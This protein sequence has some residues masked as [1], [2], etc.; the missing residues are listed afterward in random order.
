MKRLPI[1]LQYDCNTM[2]LCTNVTLFHFKYNFM[3]SCV[4]NV[5][6]SAYNTGK[7]AYNFCTLLNSCKHHFIERKIRFTRLKSYFNLSEPPL[8]VCDWS[9]LI[10]GT[11]E[12]TKKYNWCKIKTRYHFLVSCLCSITS[13]YHVFALTLEVDGWSVSCSYSISTLG[14]FL[15]A[16]SFFPFPLIVPP[17]SELLSLLLSLS[18]SLSSPWSLSVSYKNN[19]GNR[20]LK[21]YRRNTVFLEFETCFYN[22]LAL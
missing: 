1:H 11:F 12:K 8:D 17:S 19:F 20:R 14:R 7:E 6:N 18:S 21:S 16:A 2:Y 5:L 10:S 3:H 13:S 15:L 9:F 22:C 4:Q